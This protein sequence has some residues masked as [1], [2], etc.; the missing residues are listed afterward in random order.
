MSFLDHFKF[1]LRCSCDKVTQIG[2]TDMISGRT[3][4]CS[5]CGETSIQLR[6][7][8]LEN[9]PLHDEIRKAK[10]AARKEV[11]R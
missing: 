2:Y 10:E 4:T 6:D 3:F 8:K 1:E 7:L 11:G 9:A 5:K